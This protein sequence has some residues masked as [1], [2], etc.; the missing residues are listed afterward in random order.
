[1]NQEHRWN[2]RCLFE[3]CVSKYQRGDIEITKLESGVIRKK[4]RIGIKHKYPVQLVDNLLQATNAHKVWER[5]YFP[6]EA[7]DVICNLMKIV[8]GIL[9]NS[10]LIE[11]L[12]SQVSKLLDVAWCVNWYSTWFTVHCCNFFLVHHIC[13]LCLHK[14]LARLHVGW[15]GSGE[16]LRVLLR[17]AMGEVNCCLLV[18][19]IVDKCY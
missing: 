12:E 7:W 15:A 17:T 9:G 1:M 18:S 14:F 2:A 3:E 11:V 10:C 16:C 6:D 4:L 5:V 8:Q 13:H 19:Q